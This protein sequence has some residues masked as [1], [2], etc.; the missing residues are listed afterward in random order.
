MTEEEMMKVRIWGVSRWKV[1]KLKNSGFPS[2]QAMIK[3]EGHAL[4]HTVSLQKRPK[5]RPFAQPNDS[6]ALEQYDQE[7]RSPRLGS[8][9]HC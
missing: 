8:T 3:E 9:Q 2:A 5:G 6:A 1:C 4:W 7:H